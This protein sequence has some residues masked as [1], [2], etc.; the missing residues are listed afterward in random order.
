MHKVSVEEAG[1]E[2]MQMVSVEH[3]A[4]QLWYKKAEESGSEAQSWDRLG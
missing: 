2:R 4:L 1:G 3:M